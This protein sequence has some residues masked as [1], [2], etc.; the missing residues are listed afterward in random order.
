VEE[1]AACGAKLGQHDA[2]DGAA[3][4]L[5]FLLGATVIPAAWAF[6]LAFAPP[7]WVHVVLWGMVSLGLIA[8]I[9]PGTKAYI[10]LLNFRHGINSAK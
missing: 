6:E 7:L 9:L 8:L 5:I 1:C 10:I 4:F 3:V 2:G